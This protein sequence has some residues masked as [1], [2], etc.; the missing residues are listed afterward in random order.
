MKDVSTLPSSGT[1][2]KKF[3]RI[4]A[5]LLK[6]VKMYR[7]V[8]DVGKHAILEIKERAINDKV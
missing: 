5:L 7:F 3:S 8:P 2:G 6:S 1:S 4:A